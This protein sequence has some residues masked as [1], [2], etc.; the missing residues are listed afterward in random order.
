ME[1]Y[2]QANQKH[3]ENVSKGGCM[4]EIFVEILMINKFYLP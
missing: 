2:E 1:K 4:P 3:S